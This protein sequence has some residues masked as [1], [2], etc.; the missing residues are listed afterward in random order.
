MK[1]KLLSFA[2]L[3]ALSSSVPAKNTVTKISQVTASV[4]LTDDID[5]VI[6]GSEPFTVT[7]SI[8]IKN[9]EH[10]SLIHI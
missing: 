9:K 7:G 10:L 6:T 5:Y 2:M 1:N 4:V 3:V 8:N